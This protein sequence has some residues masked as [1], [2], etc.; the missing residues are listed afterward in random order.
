MEYNPDSSA[1]AGIWGRSQT[2]LPLLAYGE[3]PNV[4]SVIAR[5]IIDFCLL[6]VCTVALG[7]FTS[8]L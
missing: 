4:S 1:V 5:F 2:L 3:N 7:R 8:N 6:Y